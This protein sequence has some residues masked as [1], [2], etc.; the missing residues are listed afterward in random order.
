MLQIEFLPFTNLETDRLLLRQIEKDDANEI[1]ALRS[2]DRV[3]QFIGRPKMSSLEEARTWIEKF[4]TALEQNEGITWAITI[5]TEN[6]LLGTI[7]FWRLEKEHYRGE[8]GYLLNPASQGKGFMHEAFRPVLKYGF[9]KM[10]LH[11]IEANVYPENNSS[12]K[13]LEKNGFVQE[14]YFK[15]NYFHDGIFTDTAVYSLVMNNA[16][17]VIQKNG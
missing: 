6:K 8:I 12:R 17:E 7:G 9:E 16:D 4:D 1:L 10:K 11:S 14:G 3:M 5:K 13:V 2:D 15:E